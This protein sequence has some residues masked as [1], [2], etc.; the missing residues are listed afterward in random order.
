MLYIVINGSKQYLV[1]EIV[2]KYGLKSGMHTPFTGFKISEDNEK[3][4]ITAEHQKIHQT[5]EDDY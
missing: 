2:K 4:R 1:K 3:E 5:A